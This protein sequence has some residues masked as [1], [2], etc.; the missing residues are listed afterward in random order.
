MGTTYEN[1]NHPLSVK[2]RQVKYGTVIPNGLCVQNA[3]EADLLFPWTVSYSCNLKRPDRGRRAIIIPSPLFLTGRTQG[4][5]SQAARGSERD[6][7][8][9]R[10]ALA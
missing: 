6:G 10:A 2:S 4:P 3:W 5:G 7:S 8:R 1:D 9:D